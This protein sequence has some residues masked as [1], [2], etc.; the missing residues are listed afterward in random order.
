MKE[1]NQVKREN[2]KNHPFLGFSI[3]IFISTHPAHSFSPNKAQPYKSQQSVK[4][5]QFITEMIIKPAGRQCVDNIAQYRRNDG[6]QRHQSIPYLPFGEESK[7][8]QPQQGTIK[9]GHDGIDGVQRI[10]T[11]DGP[12]QKHNQNEHHANGKMDEQ[13]PAIGDIFLA[14]VQNVD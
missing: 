2:Y 9:I 8:K 4:H 7:N 11:V 1:I 13:P 6:D 12:E 3:N 5:Q 10:L 14:L